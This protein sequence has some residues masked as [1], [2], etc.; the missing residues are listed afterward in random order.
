MKVSLC[1]AVI[2]ATYQMFVLSR[3]DAAYVVCSL[4]TCGCRFWMVALGLSLSACGFA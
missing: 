1:D 4:G 3:V 2:S